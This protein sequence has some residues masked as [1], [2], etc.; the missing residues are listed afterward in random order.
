MK[1]SRGGER[2][3]GQI[4]R[5]WEASDPA[6]PMPPSAPEDAPN[7]LCVVVDDI[8]FGWIEPFGGEIRTPN[9]QRLA[10]SGLKYTNF[11]TTALCSPTRAALLTGR[12]HH[13]VGM[14]AITEMATGFPRHN[15]RQPQNK[16]GI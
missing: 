13:S 2:A 1:T 16:A 7:V 14:A 5:T 15:A 6:F 12:N 4:G 11:T 8:G 9:I 10:D 3:P